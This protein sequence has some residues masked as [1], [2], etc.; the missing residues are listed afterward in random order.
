[1]SSP[2]PFTDPAACSE[3]IIRR[4]G[5]D[6][7]LAMPL[8]LGKPVQL[9]NALYAR[10]KADPSLQ[11]TILTALLP[12]INHFDVPVESKTSHPIV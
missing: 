2:Q 4:V 11:L 9:A 6:I 7:R 3:E 1:M 10:A 5:P 8:G 12:N